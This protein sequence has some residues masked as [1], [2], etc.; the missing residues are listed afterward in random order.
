LHARVPVLVR[1]HLVQGVAA[2]VGI[3]L[4]E[5]CGLNDLERI[6]RG[7]EDLC[8][9]LIGIEGDRREELV[10]LVLAVRRAR[11]GLRG[12]RDWR[13]LCRPRQRRKSDDGEKCDQ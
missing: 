8:Q 6:G 13:G 9:Q 4:H 2:K 12:R 3:L 5:A 1:D 7:H 11:G 10:E